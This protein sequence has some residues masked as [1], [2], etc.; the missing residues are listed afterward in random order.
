VLGGL[1]SFAPTAS[2]GTNAPLVF[3][4]G[5]I[6][7]AMWAGIAIHGHR[8]AAR[9]RAVL[10]LPASDASGIDLLWLAPFIVAFS[11]VFWSSAGRLGDPGLVLSDYVADWR[12]GRVDP[13]AGR[14]ATPPATTSTVTDVWESQLANLRNDLVRLAALSGPGSGIEPADP[15]GSVQ[16]T[17][18]DDVEPG[19][20]VADIEVVRRESVRTQLFG[21]LPSTTQRLVTLEKLG[22]AELRQVDLPGQFGGHGWQI[23]RVEVGGI[24]VGD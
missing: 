22:S 8:V 13:A 14:F 6:I 5:A 18:R 7:L 11:T 2:S 16:W 3:L 21:L 9:R 15:L 24:V 23:V 17:A 19:T 1:A 12:A 20:F 10:D 4:A